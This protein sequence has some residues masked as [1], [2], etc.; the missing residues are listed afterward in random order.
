[1]ERDQAQAVVVA[2]I[3]KT[4]AWFAALMNLLVDK[5]LN[6]PR[7]RQSFQTQGF[8]AE[9]VGVMLQSWRSSTK[10]QYGSYIAR[11]EQYCVERNIDRIRPSVAQAVDFLLHLHQ[12]RLSYSALNTA[13]SALSCILVMDNGIPFGQQQAVKR[14]MTGFFNINPPKPRYAHTWDVKVVLDLL[15]TWNPI[16]ELSLKTLTLKL[17]MLLALVSG[18]RVQTLCLLDL[19]HYTKGNSDVVFPFQEPLKHLKEG[20]PTQHVRLR[21]YPGNKNLCVITALVEYINRTEP[22]RKHSRLLLSFVKPHSPV[23]RD[24]L[25]RWLRNVMSQSGIDVSVFKA[26]SC[27]SAAHSKAKAAFVPMDTILQTGGWAGSETFLSFMI[28]AIV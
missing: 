1:L 6:L 8:S 22:L 17:T 5:P 27:R 9:A 16:E 28:E 25:A 12:L 3:W 20:R 10:R 14:L 15:E 18:Q 7:M 2:P 26:H 23:S 13:R 19:E 24:T 11:W 4:Q 21:S